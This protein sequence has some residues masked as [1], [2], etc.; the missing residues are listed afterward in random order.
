[1]N[2]ELVWSGAI[3]SSMNRTAR[4]CILLSKCPFWCKHYLQL[5]FTCAKK[6]QQA[7]LGSLSRIAGKTWAKIMLESS[8]SLYLPTYAA[9]MPACVGQ[10]GLRPVH[11]IL[12]KQQDPWD[13]CMSGPA[14]FTL[15]YNSYLE[16]LCG[17]EEM[18]LPLTVCCTV[19]AASLYHIVFPIIM[20]LQSSV[21]HL[22]FCFYYQWVIS[23]LLI[24][25]HVVMSL[26]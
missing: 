12:Q 2:N 15:R 11:L 18:A 13:P 10:W 21:W 24:L 6:C 17:R 25:C 19:S 3:F 22:I 8:E 1:M 26:H 5:R 4:T 14:R 16:L 23:H 9:S 7:T 20:S